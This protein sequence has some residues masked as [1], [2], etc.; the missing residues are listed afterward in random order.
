MIRLLVLAVMLA[1][2][3]SAITIFGLRSDSH[4]VSFD[5]A[6][7]GT[8]ADIGL[9]TGLSGGAGETT[10]GIDVRPVDG[11][12]YLFTVNTAQVMT[13]Y[14][15]NT[16][17]AVA[18]F[19]GATA[20][21]VAGLNTTAAHGIGFNPT[22]DRIRVANTNAE[23]C[24]I[25]PFNGSLA[26]ND[27]DLSPPG[28][29]IVAVA[30]DR[31]FSG[32]TQSTLF[33]IDNGSDSL[34]IIGGP[35]GTPSPNGGV[36]T[37]FG[38]LGINIVN[39]AGMDIDPSS[40]VCYAACTVSATLSLYSINLFTG[41]ATSIGVIGAG[42][43]NMKSIALQQLANAAPV[44]T[45]PATQSTPQDTPLILTGVNGI[46]IADGDSGVNPIE[47]QIVANNG[48]VSFASFLGLTFVVGNGLDD[49]VIVCS[50]TLANLNAALATVTFEPATGFNG[51][52]G[53]SLAVSDG[54]AAGFGGGGSSTESVVV[55][56][57]D[58][59]SNG[60]GGGDD[61]SS[62][63]TSENSGLGL[64]LA[65]LALIFAGRR[66]ARR[67]LMPQV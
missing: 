21:G 8:V 15:L 36:L 11:A 3:L 22:V 7:P 56:V 16:S 30:Y 49:I 38:A 28:S 61:E 66:M 32:T 1:S 53:I 65:A 33:A 9:V 45:A 23:N 59:P 14:T 13:T 20:S 62:C 48:T 40:G 51:Y 39:D 55:A 52:A 64:L 41:A 46:S 24:R 42:G 4:L 47:L 54:G 44:I 35:N 18:T 37:L 12:L 6:T 26:G 5:S 31:S 58:V 29:S 57:G 19:I 2:P 25:N 10:V 63:A 43:F 67:R 34:Y 50:G 60:G 17:T 27:T